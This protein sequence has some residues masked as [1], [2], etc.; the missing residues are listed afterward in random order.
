[1]FAWYIE[2]GL[3]TGEYLAFDVST[4]GGFTWAEKARLRGNVDPE[5]MRHDVNLEL[6]GLDN[7][8]LRFRGTMSRY[9]EDAN[10][11]EVIVTAW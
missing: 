6:T 8:R 9:N 2:S 11:D 3:D 1:M 5:N 10:I 4:D 7:L